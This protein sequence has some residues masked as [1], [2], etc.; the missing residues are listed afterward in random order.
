LLCR[1]EVYRHGFETARWWSSAVAELS[2]TGSTYQ[3]LFAFPNPETG[4]N[5]PGTT[6]N[7]VG[8]C[9]QNPFV[10]GCG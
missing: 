8:H 3:Y 1:T 2:P 7:F 10:F 9:T 6:T 4:N 5:Q